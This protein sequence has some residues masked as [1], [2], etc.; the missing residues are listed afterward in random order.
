MGSQVY[1]KGEGGRGGGGTVACMGII[2]GYCW[3]VIFTGRYDAPTMTILF[4]IHH[5]YS[6]AL[7]C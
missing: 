5:C 6:L 1:W 3:G 7:H 2:R 4:F